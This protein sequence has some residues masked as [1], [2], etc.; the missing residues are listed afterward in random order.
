MVQDFIE[1]AAL[2][3]GKIIAADVVRHSLAFDMRNVRL[4]S[5]VL[6]AAVELPATLA[7]RC[8]TARL[9][10]PSTG[11]PYASVAGGTVTIPLGLD[12]LRDLDDASGAFFYCDAVL[13]DS[14]GQA[15]MLPPASQCGCLLK[16]THRAQ[17]TTHGAAIAA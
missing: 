7:G 15:L 4:A 12:A 6:S 5:N 1:L 17:G 16:I 2:G 3:T 10:E 8:S 14:S 11:R 13:E 9:L